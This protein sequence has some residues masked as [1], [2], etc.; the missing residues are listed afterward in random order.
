MDPNDQ[1]PTPPPAPADPPQPAPNPAPAPE[2][3]DQSFAE[4]E[5]EL[6][7][8]PAPAAKPTP[9]APAAGEPP[10]DPA[11]P[12]EDKPGKPERPYKRILAASA[13]TKEQLKALEQ[14]NARLRALAGQAPAAQAQA[15]AQGAPDSD[16][17]GPKAQPM[18]EDF[19]KDGVFDSK[20]YM[21][22]FGAWNRAEALR[23]VDRRESERTKTA[24]ASEETARIQQAAQTWQ[25]QATELAQQDTEIGEALTFM[26]RDDVARF[27]PERVQVQ[28]LHASPMVAVAIA[29]RQD[30][31]DIIQS[32]DVESS[33][34]LIGKIEGILE[35]A[36][37]ESVQGGAG[38]PSQSQ[39]AAPAAA[40]ASRA[41]NGQFT[42]APAPARVAP[43]GPMDLGGGGSAAV[44]PIDM[45]FQ[46]YEKHMEQ[47]NR[48]G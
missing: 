26:Q 29:S 11:V 17:Y 38:Q 22:A 40:P 4:Y 28:L 37:G 48:R 31:L 32:G 15:P 23:E 1:N 7:G 12:P 30:L 33:L 21:S 46:T 2:E 19:E 9:A 14:E 45:D 20:A 25:T 3:R 44:H 35:M 47:Q 16:Q 5:A 10:T 34:R 24:Q 8:K 36:R 39:P 13:Q 42:P 41:P 27:I 43:R 6:E 18:P